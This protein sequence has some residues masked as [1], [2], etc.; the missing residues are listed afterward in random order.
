VDVRLVLISHTNVG[1]TSLAR[2]LLRREVGEVVDSAHTTLE[3]ERHEL[4]RAGDDALVLWD[5]PGFGNSAKLRRRL[6]DRDG[7]VGWFLGQVWDRVRDPGLWSA[8]QAMVAVREEGDL[9]LYLVNASEDPEFATYIDAELEVLDWLG[10]PVLV[11][12]NQ[13]PPAT[14]RD[15][16]ARLES[17][18]RDALDRRPVGGVL[19]LDAFERCWIDETRVLTAAADLLDG[20]ARAAMSRLLPAFQADQLARLDAAV[21]VL[22]RAL[23]DTVLDRE[24]LGRGQGNRIGRAAALRRLAERLGKRVA[25]AE[26]EFVALEQLQGE[27]AARVEAAL[28]ATR[29]HGER[30]SPTSGAAGGAL[31]GAGA[32]AAVDLLL[33][34]LTFGIFTALGATLSG[35]AAWSWCWQA[36]DRRTLGWSAAFVEELAADLLARYLAVIHHGRARGRYDGAALDSW[37]EAAVEALAAHGADLA[38]LTGEL[39]HEPADAAAARSAAD[40]LARALLTGA[41]LDE[42]P[43]ARWIIDASA[44]DAGAPQG[45]PS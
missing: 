24:P 4:A 2:T 45:D 36:V 6:A 31:L 41:L 35:A 1:K 3:N 39:D 27:A 42:Y 40:R 10:V 25:A 29:D 30:P 34:G 38:T 18:W 17:A 8:Q 12:L 13:L 28:T 7:P 33:G 14:R 20:E 32:G 22:A 15:E 16:R 23:A 19:T 9:V 43:D 44:A 21:G 5:T 37:R 26:A 11:L